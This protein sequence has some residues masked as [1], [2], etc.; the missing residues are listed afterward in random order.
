M[1]KKSTSLLVKLVSTATKIT[2]DGHKKPTGYF[3]IK[4][5]NPKR[6]TNKLEMIKYDPIVRYHILFK[7]EKLK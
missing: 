7:E 2:N 6:V 5:R 1:A 4:R 3:Y